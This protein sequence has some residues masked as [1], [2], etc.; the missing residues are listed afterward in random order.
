[1]R[2]KIIAVSATVVLIVGLLSIALMRVTISGLVVKPERARNEAFRAVAAAGAEFQLRSLTIERWLS[3]QGDKADLQEPFLIA[4][5]KARGE[6][7]TAIADRLFADA[8]ASFKSSPPSMVALVDASG[9]AIGRN[10]TQILRGDDLGKF[11]PEMVK[12]I[13]SGATGSSIWINRSRNEQMLVSY[14]ALRSSKTK[15]VI[16]GIVVGVPLDDGMLTRVS[17][18]TSG[19][20]IALVMRAGDKLEIAARSNKVNGALQTGITGPLSNNVLSSIGSPKPLQINASELGFVGSGVGMGGYGLSPNMGLVSFAAIN[21]VD[22]VWGLL[23][24]IV[25]STVLGLCLAIAGGYMLGTYFSRPILELE[26]GIFAIINGQVNRRFETEH[27]DLGGLASVINSLL[28]SLMGVP[29]DNTDDQ[30]RPSHAPDPGDFREA[31]AVDE[32][33]ATKVDREAVL[34]LKQEDPDSYYRRL[35]GEYITAKKAIGEKVDHI[36]EPVFVNRI[37]GL[38]EDSLNKQGKNVRY[39]VEHRGQEVRL[40][41]IPLDLLSLSLLL[42]GKTIGETKRPRLSKELCVGV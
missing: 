28:N 3:E 22:S 37:R 21:S 27:S 36:T 8:N 2:G 18:E 29:E 12:T 20:P 14:A 6:K 32:P 10:G 11:Y 33:S 34:A 5:E 7:A 39:A 26:N 24:P 13:K 40:I 1:M 4:S 15:E 42:M 17:E 38:E 23:W 25:G 35:Y 19:R 41:A 30:G 31:M 16:G 9:I